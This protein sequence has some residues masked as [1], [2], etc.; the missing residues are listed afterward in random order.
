MSVFAGLLPDTAPLRASRSFRLLWLGQLG[1]QTGTQLRMVALPFQVYLLTGSSLDVGLLGLFQAI[2]LLLFALFGGAIADTFDRRRILVI[3]QSGLLLTSLALGLVTHLGLATLPV[4]YGLTAVGAA[5]SAID[6]PVRGSLVP[7]LVE[8]R[9]LAAA[10]TLNQVLFQTASIAGPAI[11]GLAIAALGVESAYWLN[12]MGFCGS[13]AAAIAIRVPQRP[14]AARFS[15]LSSVVAGLRYVGASPILLAA[16]LVD[17]FAMF[18]A[19]PLALFPFY[20]QEVFAVGPQSVGL[21]YAAPGI[22]ALLAALTAGWIPRLRRHGNALLI[23]IVAWG[24]GVAA[25]GALSPA[26]FGFALLL[27]AFAFAADAASAI[28]RNTLLQSVVRDEMR[29]RLTSIYGLF[30]TLGPTLG[31]ARA[32]AVGAL[33]SPKFSVI[34]GGLACAA[35]AALIALLVPQLRSYER[36]DRP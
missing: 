29:G 32:G 22:G 33:V 21:L 7:T 24:F 30:V 11:G 19:H 17:F 9:D 26:A 35:V 34:S 3:T 4:L 5:F 15:P 18:L 36:S 10:I 25:F 14:P 27:I 16:M 1:S 20:A 13:I 31:Q 28:L 8:R 23:S 2:P 12:A 6:Q